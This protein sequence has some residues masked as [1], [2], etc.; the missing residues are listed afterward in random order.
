MVGR[1]MPAKNVNNA[2]FPFPRRTE[3][4]ENAIQ[5]RDEE[6]GELFYYFP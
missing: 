5:G 1:R 3:E 2:G 6:D 4:E